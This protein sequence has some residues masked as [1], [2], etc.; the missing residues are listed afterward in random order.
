MRKMHNNKTE[1]NQTEWAGM[2]VD[3]ICVY[4]SNLLTRAF[5]VWTVR[6]Q[7]AFLSVCLSGLAGSRISKHMHDR[8]NEIFAPDCQYNFIRAYYM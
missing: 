2:D 4:T 5:C 6:H 8:T 1:P 7:S 3:V